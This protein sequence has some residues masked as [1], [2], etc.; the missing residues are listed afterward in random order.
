MVWDC[1]RSKPPP[2]ALWFLEVSQFN[3]LT[4]GFHLQNAYIGWHNLVLDLL[5][6]NDAAKSRPSTLDIWDVWPV[7]NLIKIINCHQKGGQNRFFPKQERKPNLFIWWMSISFKTNKQTENIL[8]LKKKQTLKK[9]LFLNTHP[10]MSPETKLVDRVD[11]LNLPSTLRILANCSG[12][13][14]EEI[15]Y[16]HTGTF[17][18]EG[19]LDSWQAPPDTRK[20]VQFERWGFR[21]QWPAYFSYYFLWVSR[22]LREKIEKC[23]W[24]WNSDDL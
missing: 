4:F 22:L 11:K 9:T 19:C 23:P 16:S 6:Y 17:Q 24:S 1:T 7:I 12:Y 5:F 8:N 18:Q 13:S 21:M 2:A 15:R 14:P 20:Q 3:L 10:S